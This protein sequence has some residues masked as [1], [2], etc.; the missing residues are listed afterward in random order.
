MRV[1]PIRGCGS[2]GGSRLHPHARK[3]G[4]PIRRSS[5]GF[6]LAT[7]AQSRRSMGGML[8]SLAAARG[9]GEGAKPNDWWFRLTLEAL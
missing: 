1:L 2:R 5:N 9:P 6:G 7:T 3:R 8:S 4:Q